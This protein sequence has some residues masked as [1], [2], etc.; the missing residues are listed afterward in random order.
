MMTQ[1]VIMYFQVS[2][3]K[4]HNRRIENL[5]IAECLAS[6]RIQALQRM[7]HEP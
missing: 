4:W 5:K 7:K 3:K 2:A 1:T 6:I